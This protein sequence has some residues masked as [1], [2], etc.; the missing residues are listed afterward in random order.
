MKWKQV[1][2]AVAAAVA[3]LFA[4]PAQAQLTEGVAAIVND[5]VIST[6]DVRQRAT[7]LLASSGIQASPEAQQRARAQAMRDLIDERLQMQEA[8]HYNVTVTDAQINSTLGDIARQNNTTPDALI[9]QLT[10]VGV[11]PATL[12]AQ[13]RADIAW[14]RL[15]GGRYGSRVRISDVEIRDA[16]AR[17]TQSSARSQY[18]VSEIFLAAESE[19][20]FTDAQSGAERLLQEMQRGAP[21]PLVARQF[22]AAP[23]AAAGGDLGWINAGEVRPEL[24]PVLDR[25]QAGQVSTP[26]RTPDGI[27]IVALRDRREG[28]PATTAT[29]LGLRQVSAPVAQRS[30]LDRARRRISDCA[31]LA[32]SLNGVSG[33]EVTDL[34]QTA[35]SDLS[36]AVR[37]QVN[38]VPQGQ[39]TALTTTGDRVSMIVVCLRETS[40][41]GVPSH[42]E[43]EN[44]LYEQELAM[45]SQ[46]YL[47]D[48][49]REA[50]II[51]R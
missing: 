21:F 40:A 16:E 9:Q 22:S 23:S 32:D 28:R 43:I 2:A 47:R 25:L 17:I 29:R 20:E 15:V 37:A 7:L 51:T 44:R 13:I 4:A 41:E 42:A 8:S 1:G 12:R 49:R 35:E 27:Y 50:T 18:L 3:C 45:L 14:R 36:D 46:R 34:G 38:G 48:L 11:N 10:G 24:Q 39:A 30:Q 31:R 6:Y 33:V 26:I 5:D 19:A